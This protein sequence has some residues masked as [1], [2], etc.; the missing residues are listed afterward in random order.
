M[1]NKPP[2]L[3]NNNLYCNNQYV[4]TYNG[5]L[6]GYDGHNNTNGNLGTTSYT[7]GNLGPKIHNTNGKLGTKSTLFKD[8]IYI[9]GNPNITFFKIPYKKHTNFNAES[10]ELNNKPKELPIDPTDV[11]I[12]VEI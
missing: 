8:D 11:D 4:V 7:N 9:V 6:G 5:D 12:G 3:I 2:S 1:N 10:I